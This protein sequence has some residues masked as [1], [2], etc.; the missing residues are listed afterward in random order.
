LRLR[1][2]LTG[3]WEVNAFLRIIRNKETY[4]IVNGNSGEVERFQF[5]EVKLLLK[6]SF[7]NFFKAFFLIY[8]DSTIVNDYRMPLP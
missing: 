2:W 5:N 1:K 7:Q 8:K 4:E 6:S 3:V